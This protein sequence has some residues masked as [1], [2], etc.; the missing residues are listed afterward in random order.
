MYVGV[1]PDPRL[2]GR[3]ALPVAH[4]HGTL[5]LWWVRPTVMTLHKLTAGDGYTYLTRQ[6][7]SA[8]QR[9]AGQ[10]LADYYAA[11]GNPPGRWL[12]AGAHD[13]DLTGVVGEAQMRALFGRGEHPDSDRLVAAA[14][15]AGASLLEARRAG[16]LGVP[17]SPD[18]ARQTVAGFD[19]VFTPV[20]SVSLLWALGDDAVRR[21]VEDAH[22]AAVADAIGWLERNAVFT[23]IGAGGALQVETQG[24]IAAAF[25][26]RESRLGDP[27]LHTHV[28]VANKVRAVVD[29]A[30]GSPRWLSIDARTLYAAAVAASERY[31]TRL[32]DNLR[33]ALGVHFVE[34][35]DT[36]RRDARPGAR[37]RR[38][39]GVAD[40]SLLA[41]TGRG[42]APVRRAAPHLPGRARPRRTPHRAA[43][44]GATGNPG[45]PRGQ[46]GPATVRRTAGRVARTRRR[47]CS[48][49]TDEV[50]S[51]VSSVIGHPIAP[52]GEVDIRAIARDAIAVLE[53][54]RSTWSRWNLLAEIERQTRPIPT[55][56]PPRRGTRL[57]RPSSRRQ[58]H[59]P[60][61]SASSP[62]PSRHHRRSSPGRTANSPAYAARAPSGTRRV[63]SSTPSSVCL[64]APANTPGC[65][66]TPRWFAKQSPR[67]STLPG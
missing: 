55:A 32:E 18:D 17:F 64:T 42:R 59:P 34:R 53:S 65:T 25:D 37:D 8:D 1:R 50:D 36:V 10:S 4:D 7:A 28:A 22:H 38:D 63:A 61:A 13:L 23:R 15:A 54:E 6:V 9:R 62:R 41:A 19:L 5:G 67:S 57:S 12:G 30:D 40:Q 26:H 21:A 11:T 24:L 52:T 35:A 16:R 58:P 43:T 49:T 51:L 14:L 31:N 48:A 39:A 2:S 29:K 66:S 60:R 27:D 56:T 3:L 44:A 33:R 45:H 47:T 46:A 20:K